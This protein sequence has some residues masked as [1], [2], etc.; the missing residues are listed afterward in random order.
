MTKITDTA[1]YPKLFQRQSILLGCQVFNVKTAAALKNIKKQLENIIV[2]AQMITN[3][4]K[5]MNFKEKYFC[6]KMEHDFRSPLTL[7]YDS[8]TK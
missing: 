5:T 1:V 4:S 2:F 7:E 6:V 8:V 3:W